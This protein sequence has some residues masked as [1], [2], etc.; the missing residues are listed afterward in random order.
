MCI[1]CKIV[2]GEIPANAVYEDAEFLAFKDLNPVAPQHFLVIPKQHIASLDAA[3]PEQANLLGRLQ[4]VAAEIARQQGMA[5]AGYRL[6]LN[7][8]ELGGQTV[9]HLH[10]HLIGGKL[11]GW[12]PYTDEAK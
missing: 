4:I 9:G 6:V 7:C 5:Q 12:P 10:Y 1:F 3:R 2:N 8:G 11:L